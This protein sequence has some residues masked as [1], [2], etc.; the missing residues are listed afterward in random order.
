MSLC[1]V[2]ALASSPRRKKHYGRSSG[3]LLEPNTA[4]T[5]I[6]KGIDA[7]FYPTPSV[8][9]TQYLRA[10]NIHIIALPAH[11]SHRTETLD[12]SI[13][14]RF[15]TYLSDVLNDCSLVTAAEVR[16]E[17]YTL[18]EL[19]HAT[20]K[21]AVTYNNIVNGFKGCGVWCSIRK[22]AIS[23][24]MCL[25]DIRNREGYESRKAAFVAFRDLVASYASTANCLRSDGPILDSGTLYTRAGALL[26]TYD[27]LE[28]LRKREES[29]VLEQEQRN[30]LQA[31]AASRRA[32]REQE[33]ADRVRLRNEAQ[34]AQHNH[35][36]W[37]AQ[38]AVR[39]VT[40]LESRG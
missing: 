18:C 10:N 23:D 7:A 1:K 29:R 20:Y 9:A 38:R 14:L 17:I 37:H 30:A 8:T 32:A 19:L 13:F 35:T 2:V 15:K 39:E 34:R 24:V 31:E 22:T 4:F 3:L 16:N 25:R 36:T 40:R 21:K 5:R 11:T 28:S 6:S 33:A 12:N 27:V 26:T